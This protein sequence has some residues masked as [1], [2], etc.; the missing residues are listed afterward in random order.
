MNAILEP[1]GAVGT[2]CLNPFGSTYSTEILLNPF[3]RR[4]L[5]LRHRQLFKLRIPLSILHWNVCRHGLDVDR[6]KS[7]RYNIEQSHSLDELLY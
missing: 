2:M 1:R 5:Q 4:E 7:M 6:D 3:Q